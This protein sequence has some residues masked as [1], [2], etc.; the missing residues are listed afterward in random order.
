MNPILDALQAYRRF[1]LAAW[2][3]TYQVFPVWA[4]ILLVGLGV[5]LLLQGGGRFFRF[6]AGPLGLW[7]GG[8]WMPLVLAKFG[9]QAS[10]PA[11]VSASA[12][13]LAGLGFAYPPGALFFA[14]GVPAGLFGGQIA[15]PA[16]WFLG[17]VPGF[18]IGGTVAAAASRPIG[19]IT[20]SI[21]GAWLLV[22]GLL[23]ALHQAGGLVETMVANP[24]GI[25]VAAGLFAAAG[26]IYQLLVQPSP[27][28]KQRLD[29]ERAKAKRH[30]AEK[31]AIEKRWAN[32][33]AKK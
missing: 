1:D 7:V 33:S 6:L 22:I 3:D 11:L 18:L 13:V 16:D 27:E 32:Y 26:S 4:G 17:F 23:S 31:R 5:L 9:L 29:A 19:A 10:N 28:E 2:V 20:A 12:L 8:V 15:G 30:A 21:V 24:W 25:L 14:I